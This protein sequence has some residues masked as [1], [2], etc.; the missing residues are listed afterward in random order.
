M[1]KDFKLEQMEAEVE[2]MTQLR[3][4]DKKNATF[5]RTPGGF[6]SLETGTG[7]WDRVQVVRLFPFTDPD[8]FISIRTIDERSKEIGVIKDLNDVSKETRQMLLEQLNLRYFTP[9]IQKIIDIKDEYGYAYFHVMTDRGECRFTINM[10]S[11]AVVRLTDSRLLITDLDEN[12][13]EIADVY[14]LSQKEQRKLDL[15]L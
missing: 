8:R 14:K 5:N 11:N 10:G 1:S 15:F 12:R 4:L 6:V 2:E 3:Y 7:K 9:L 13:F